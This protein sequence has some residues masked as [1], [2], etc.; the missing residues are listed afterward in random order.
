[1]QDYFTDKGKTDIL[2]STR[3]GLWE[4]ILRQG[5]EP[6]MHADSVMLELLGLDA[7]PEPEEC[8][9]VWYN[10]IQDEYKGAVQE[11]VSKAIASTRAEVQEVQYK[12]NHP[13]WG[14]I[15][16]RCGGM[17]DQEW[18]D[19]IRLRGYHQNITDTIMFQQEYDAVIQTLSG[20]YRGILLCD[21]RDG[22]Y[23]IIKA[24]EDL[25][26]NLTKYTDFREFLRGYSRSCIR[27]EF[28]NRIERLAEYGY[29]REQFRSGE[30]QIE[31]LYRIRS[32]S[33]Q[34]VMAIPFAP[35]SDLK[36]RAILA[37]DIQDGEVEKRMDEVT[38]KVAVSTIYTLVLSLDPATQEYSCLH[39]MGDRLKIA[40]KG[41]LSDLLSQVMPAPGGQGEA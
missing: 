33:W 18:E 4:I 38:A 12:W 23:K 2:R 28:R 27:P 13:L 15:S 34:R 16:V 31:E 20:R 10:R 21:L 9:Q 11:T 1:M 19:G 22:S 6:V 30:K 37:F 5:R 3:T 41:M 14:P 29:M 32:G 36:A 26:D 25:K 35:E 39:Y 8:Y 7:A 24:A 40:P 17:K